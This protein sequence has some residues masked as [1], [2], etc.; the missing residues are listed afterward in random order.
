MFGFYKGGMTHTGDHGSKR[1][2]VR[3]LTGN[4][5]P[6]ESEPARREDP[7]EPSPDD[8][9]GSESGHSDGQVQITRVSRPDFGL[10]MDQN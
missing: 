7:P 3:G 6:I 4:D 5:R 9:S 1:Q 10:D 2:I 8:P